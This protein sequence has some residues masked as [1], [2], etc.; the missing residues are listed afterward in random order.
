M[1]QDQAFK[2]VLIAHSKKHSRRLAIARDHDRP[3]LARPEEI[4]EVG[5][6]S[7]TEAIFITP[8]LL[9]R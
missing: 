8:L 1:G 2:F 3:P 6:T 5:S 4:A 9:R 7:A